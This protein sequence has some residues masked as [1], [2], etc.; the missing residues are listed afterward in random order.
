FVISIN[1][2][3]SKVD[4]QVAVVRYVLLLSKLKFLLS[5]I[6]GANSKSTIYSMRIVKLIFVC[7]L[8]RA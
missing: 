4:G 6:S 2:T 5:I 7:C 1:G 3:L 8:T